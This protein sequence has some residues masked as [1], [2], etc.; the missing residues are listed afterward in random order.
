MDENV[1]ETAFE[2]PVPPRVNNNVS[3]NSS[4]P[5]PAYMTASWIVLIVGIVVY[6]IGL[7]NAEMELNEKGYYLTILLFGLFSAV[8]LQKCVRDKLE[9]IPVTAMFVSISWFG[10]TA[11]ILLLIV[12]LWNA[13]LWLSEK[14]FYGISYLLSI[15]S[16]VTVQ[17]NIRDSR[18]Q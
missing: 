17:K 7:Y 5:S 18:K 16:A 1:R 4:A 3:N 13:D 14:G 15:Y 6:L 9:G 2:R 10:L 12:G 8:A 11:A